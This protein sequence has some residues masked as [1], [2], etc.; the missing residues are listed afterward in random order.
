MFNNFIGIPFLHKG[1]TK[2]GTDCWGFCRMFYKEILNKELPD[3]LKFYNET[4]NYQNCNHIYPI[5]KEHFKRISKDEV[6]KFDIV[7]LNIASVPVHV[8]IYLDELKFLHCME[9]TG[10]IISRFEDVNFRNKIDSFWRYE[11]TS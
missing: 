3:L 10:S 11:S 6:K 2:E 4:V 1:K 5:A 8:G 7:L 9:G